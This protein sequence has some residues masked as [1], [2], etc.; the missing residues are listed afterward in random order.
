M[1]STYEN[2]PRAVSERLGGLR[3]KF[4][5]SLYDRVIE[6]EGLLVH[7]RA[8][9]TPETALHAISAR[10]HKLA[11]VAPTL[12]FDAL[13]VQAR[14]VEQAID[15]LIAQGCPRAALAGTVR[16]IDGFLDLLEVTID[17]NSAA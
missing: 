3:T 9:R 2:T 11:G 10:A 7:V 14:Q 16:L 12:G 1:T 8:D 5:D 15:A 13:G 17:Q 6:I 4:V